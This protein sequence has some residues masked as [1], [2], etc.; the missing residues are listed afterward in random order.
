M[1]AA[2]YYGVKDC[3]ICGTD[4]TNYHNYP[5]GTPAPGTHDHVTG[6]TLPVTLG[7]EF[8]G[9]IVEVPENCP[10]GVGQ[11]VMVDPRLYCSEC[12]MCK[13]GDT[14]LCSKLGFVGLS[15]GGGGGFSEF[16]AVDPKRCYPIADSSLDTVCLIEPL[17]VARHALKVT[18][19]SDFRDKSSL[20]LGAG[21]I[22][23]AVI[24]NL[25][26][27]GTGAIFVSEPSSLRREYA[28]D[29]VDAGINPQEVNLVD[30]IEQLTNG[31]GVDIVFDC[32]GFI[33]AMAPA[34]SSLR[35]KGKY[36]L[37]AAPGKPIMLPL[38]EWYAR[39]IAVVASVAYNDVDFREVVDDFNQGKFKGVERMVSSR[40]QLDQFVS[41]GLEVLVTAKDGLLKVLVEPK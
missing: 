1:R 26:A 31:N 40:I 16:V 30:T 27:V 11:T 21:P 28:K 32:A 23:L 35:K 34:M 37:V 22:G 5:M 6:D 10:L 8:C 24:H 19:F 39:E 17:A 7:H 4:L 13:Q 3:G 12:S 15:G 38:L 20:I 2:R 25:K 29:L 9:R 14:N 41:Q 33:P 18:G 36:V